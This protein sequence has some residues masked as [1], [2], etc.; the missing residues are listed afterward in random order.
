MFNKNTIYGEKIMDTQ[1]ISYFGTG[2]LFI[3]A[4]FSLVFMSTIV[5]HNF[6]FNWQSYQLIAKFT[7]IGSLVEG[8]PVKIAGVNVGIVDKISLD[9][10]QQKA[11]VSLQIKKDYKINIDATA[12]IVSAGIF[13][14]Q[15]INI[16][17]GTEDIFLKPHQTFFH[18]N[19]AIIIE[20]LLSKLIGN[21][22]FTKDA[23]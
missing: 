12:Q 23:K 21:S 7:N 13:G 20:N 5:S 15:Y 4:L 3:V 1:K 22:F 11:L 6:S 9:Q 10:N 2:I 19:S 16:L 17:M 14:E 18:T 8:A